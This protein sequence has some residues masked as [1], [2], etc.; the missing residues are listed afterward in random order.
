MAPTRGGDVGSNGFQ[1]SEGSRSHHVRSI[2]RDFKR[3]CNMGLRSQI[4]NLVGPDGVEP[5]TKRG[6]VGEVSVMELHPSLE[7]VVRVDVDVVNTLRIEVGRPADQAV[8]FVAFVE[9]ELGQVRTI[10]TCDASDQR[11]LPFSTRVAV[12][13]SRSRSGSGSGS[14]IFG[15]HFL[16][17]SEWKKEIDGGF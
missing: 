8:D 3:D 11:D 15:C 1:Q 17:K 16:S 2:I 9:E 5:A 7:R 14:I 12:N 13:G 10:L 6:S 4:V